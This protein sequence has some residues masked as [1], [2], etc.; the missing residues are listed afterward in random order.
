MNGRRFA[1]WIGGAIFSLLLFLFVLPLGMSSTIPGALVRYL[2][3][4]WW[5]FLERNLPQM[6]WN[7][8]L[9]AT[10]VV[11]SILVVALGNWLLAA[12]S[13]Q[14]GRSAAPNRPISRWQWR[15][16]IG[17]Y[18]A[19]WILFVIAFG[20]AGVLRHTAW[21]MAYDRPWYQPRINPYV[22]TM[23]AQMTIA[24]LVLDNNG[25]LEATCKE[26]R[27][28]ASHLRRQYLMA[29]EV[30]VIFYGDRSNQVAAYLIIPRGGESIPSGV[31][32]ASVPGTNRVLKPIS[33]LQST[34]DDLDTR[35]P[36]AAR[37]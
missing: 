6:S 17:L 32:L 37:P 29:D 31:F 3:F 4:G 12:V 15:W 20:A 21:L 34:V 22:E 10:G 19:V 5:K 30:N 27:R 33:E 25:D 1:F 2:P 9:V 8:S 18:A 26:Y 36:R 14:L 7:W 28:E 35:F 24:Q 13:R 23:E 16:T 11:C